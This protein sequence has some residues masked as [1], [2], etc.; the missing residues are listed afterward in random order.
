MPVEPMRQVPQERV[1]GVGGASLEHQPVPSYSQGYG[2]AI[3]KEVLKALDEPVGG[4]LEVGVTGWVHRS[5][6]EDDR[7]FDQK[8][9]QLSG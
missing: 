9:G 6:M 7:E 1:V 4:C 5:L 2:I 8:V 3:S